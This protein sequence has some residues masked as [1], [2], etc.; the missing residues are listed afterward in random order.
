MKNKRRNIKRNLN[1]KMLHNFIY[2]FCLNN[3]NSF[4]FC[5][6]QLYE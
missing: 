2:I 5:D 1:Y 4:E 3:C 6:D